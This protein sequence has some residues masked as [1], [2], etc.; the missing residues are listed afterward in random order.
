MARE[1][2]TGLPGRE[3]AYPAAPD[4]YTERV[5]LFLAAAPPVNLAAPAS[6]LIPVRI[7]SLGYR[8]NDPR[9]EETIA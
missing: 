5:F 1:A 2:S 9:L 4:P 8:P 7:K 6:L 3:P